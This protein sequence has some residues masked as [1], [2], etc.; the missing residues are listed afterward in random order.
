MTIGVAESLVEYGG[1]NGAHMAQR[2]VEN[3]EMEPWR[4]YG[5]GPPHIFRLI[6]KGYLWNE[7]AS[8]IYPGG[9]FGNGA[10]MRVAPLGLLFWNRQSELRDAVY[11]SS[12]ITHAHELGMEGAALQAM[13]VSLALTLDPANRLDIP[14]FIKVLLEFTTKDAYRQK[15]AKFPVLLEY[16]RDRSKIVQELGHGIEAFN[17]VPTAIFSFLVHPEDFASTIIYAVSLGGDTDTK[18]SM[19]GAISGAHLGIDALPVEWLDHLENR[20]YISDLGT[21]LWELLN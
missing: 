2:F 11:E 14:A 20:T 6:K 7:V 18:A 3:Y 8:N 4:G 17:S 16:S 21:R 13:A 12:R 1:L 5:P 19:A 15:I 9:S 10:A